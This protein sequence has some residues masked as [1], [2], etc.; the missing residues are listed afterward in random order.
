MGMSKT[1]YAK[2][3]RNPEGEKRVELLKRVLEE[4]SKNIDKEKTKTPQELQAEKDINSWK[5]EKHKV[6]NI[7]E[8]DIPKQLIKVLLNTN[9]HYGI[10]FRGEGGVGKTVL[11]M[12]EVKKNL[13]PDEW[14]YHNGYTTPLSLYQFLYQHRDKKL[15]VLDDI[16]GI[17]TN[18][19]SLAIL[20]GALWDTDG[21]RMVQYNTTS[22]RN[23]GIPN[24]FFIKAKIIILCNKLPNQNDISMRAVMSRTI[25]F[26]VNFSY[27]QK[28]DICFQIIDSHEEI[29]P[30]NRGVAKKILEENTSIATKDF[31]FRTL[32]KLLAFIKYDMKKAKELFNATTE[33]DEDIQ[34]F[35][36]ATERFASVADQIKEFGLLTGKSRATFF[37]IKKSLKVS[38]K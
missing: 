17:F 23:D 9:E 38:S 32:Q 6:L 3:A 18:K 21:K 11:T 5:K 27:E 7:K 26:P 8:F 36:V 25:S 33:T 37:R 2:P 4:A 22:R 35:L 12:N 29:P 28:K 19:N 1:P 16:E 10:I 20:K 15:L 34:Q 30:P 24:Q 31:N 14:E 13:K